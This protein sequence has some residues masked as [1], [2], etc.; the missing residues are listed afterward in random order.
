[1]IHGGNPSGRSIQYEC[2]I[3]TAI[4]VK[5]VWDQQCINTERV[6]LENLLYKTKEKDLLSSYH[7]KFISSS[8]ISYKFSVLAS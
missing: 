5:L 7:Y 2:S 4:D 3:V 1:M 8:Y 6:E